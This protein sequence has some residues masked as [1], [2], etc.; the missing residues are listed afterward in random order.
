MDSLLLL[1][2]FFFP[3][4]ILFVFS[5]KSMQSIV[6]FNSHSRSHCNIVLL[7]PIWGVLINEVKVVVII[8]NQLKLGN[9]DVLGLHKMWT[10]KNLPQKS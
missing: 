9:P 4:G 2:F 10:T 3:L 5:L 8:V 7:L 6:Y 1:F